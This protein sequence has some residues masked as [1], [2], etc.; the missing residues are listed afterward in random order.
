[1][2]FRTAT[3]DV[4]VAGGTLPAGA[5]VAV[6]IGSANRDERR[7]EDPDRFDIER[8]PRGHLA[9]GFGEHFCLGSALARLEA[10]VALEA[11]L[12]ELAY[13]ERTEPGRELVDSFLVR[14]PKR[15]ELRRAA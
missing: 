9:F 6:L 8:E 15:L 10:R 11:L 13:V 14:G 12:P 3:R 5:N 1:M 7:F 4:E 2:V